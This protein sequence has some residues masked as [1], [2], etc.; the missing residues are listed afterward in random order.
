MASNSSSVNDSPFSLASFVSFLNNNFALIFIVGLFFLG[1]FLTGSLWTENQML[2]SGRG[3][4][5]QPI[6]AADPTA[7]APTGPTADQLKQA[8]PVSAED[9]I[10]GS[11]DAKV[12]LVEYS[13][14]ECPFCARFHP[15]ITAI[16]EEFGNDVAWV[17]R[18]YPLSFHPNAQ[19]AAEASECVAEQKGD[20]GFWAYTDAIFE[21]TQRLGSISSANISEAA[22]A[23]GANMT[24]FQECLD[25]GRM[26]QKVTDQMAGGTAAGI[27][28]TPGTILMAKDGSVELINGALPIEQVRAMVQNYL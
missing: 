14:F 5:T 11:R 22:E 10:R 7:A 16:K 15:T 6:A 9:H 18:H 8:P 2:R 13:D 26:A 20:E 12:V 3:T 19:K 25:S 21:T 24:S 28:G 1:G 23:A 17:Y 4:A 27:S